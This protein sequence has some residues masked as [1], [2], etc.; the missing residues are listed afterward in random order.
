M[1]PATEPTVSLCAEPIRSWK[2]ANIIAVGHETKSLRRYLTLACLVLSA[3]VDSL[4]L[5][6]VM[7]SVEHSSVNAD[8]RPPAAAARFR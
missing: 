7:Y 1:M 5:G 6:A 3:F 8:V 2:R 4:H